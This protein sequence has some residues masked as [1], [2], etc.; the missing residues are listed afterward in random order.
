MPDTYTGNPTPSVGVDPTTQ[1]DEVAPYYSL[2]LDGDALNVEGVNR[3]FRPM[4]NLL[5]RVKASAGFIDRAKT[6]VK[7]QYFSVGL[8]VGPP[9]TWVGSATYA[10][11]DRVLNDTGRVYVATVGG[12]AA[13]SG[14][15]T[16]EGTGIVDGAVTWDY[17]GKVLQVDSSAEVRGTLTVESPSTDQPLLAST[18]AVTTRRYDG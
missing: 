17:E 6:W 14:G 8:R 9:A 4:A 7:R 16:G 11:G 5:A 12:V 2:P 15:P 18:T 3:V 13:A 10:V 1:P